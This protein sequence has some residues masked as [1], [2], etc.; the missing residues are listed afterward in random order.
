MSEPGDFPRTLSTAI[1]AIP[2]PV[3]TSAPATATEDEAR[4]RITALEKEARAMGPLPAAALLFHEMGLLWESPLKH[5]R[6]AAV[7]YQSAFKLAP[8]FLAN[9]RAA[10]RLFAEVGN[11]VMVVQLIDA[12]LQATDARRARA[13]LLFEKGQ[14]LEQRLSKETDGAAAVA[15][16]LSLEPEDVTL[17]VQLESYYSEKADYPSLVQVYRLLARH[18]TED[19]ARAVFLTSAGLLLEDRI[20]DLPAAAAAFREAFRFDR[21]D[22]QLLGAIKRVAQREGTV[23]EELAALA[24]EAESQGVSAAPTFLQISKAYERLGRPEDALAALLAARRVSPAD[25]LVLAELARVYEAQLRFTELADVLLSWVQVSTDETEF[26]SINLRL[27]SIYEQLQRDPEASE[28]YQAVLTRAPG[29]VGALSGLGKLHYRTQNWLGLYEAYVAEAAAADDPRLKASRNYKAAETLEERLGQVDQAIAKYNECLMLSPGFLPAQKA[30]TRLYEKHGRWQDLITM[31]E[32][33]LLQTTDRDQQINMLNKIGALYED[34]ISDVDRAIEC[35]KRVLD[36]SPD[37]LPTMH[38]LGRLYERV[39]R[40]SDLLDLNEQETRL[41]SDTKQIVSLAHRN[42]EILEEHVKDRPAAIAAWERVLQLS[43][44]YLPALRALGRL[45]GQ[46]GRWEALIKMYRAEAEIAPSTDQAA[47]LI[48]KIGELY[49]QKVFD[50]DQAIASYREALMLAPTHMPALRSLA[51]IYRSQGAWE[52]LIEILHA[53]AANR[54][55]PTERANA[56]FQ[57]AAIW[58]DHLSRP[59]NAIDGYQEVLRLSPGHTTALQQLE[60]LLTAKDDVKELIVLLDQQTQV[61]TEAARI[62]AW[63]K[64]ARLYLDRLNEPTRAATCC[65][66]ALNIEKTNLTALRLLERIRVND[67]PRRAELRARVAEAIGDPRL[68]AAIKFSSLEGQATQGT[69]VVDQ[70]K[71][72]YAEDPTDEALGLL[73]ERAL[74]RAGDAKG[75]VELYERRRAQATD[76]ADLLQLL[77]RIGDLHETR[78]GDV[79]GAL[80]AYEKALESAPDLFPALMGRTRCALKV[81]NFELART[82]LELVAQT[83]RDATSAMQ[84]LLE[85]ARVAKEKEQ[86]DELAIGLYRKVLDRDPLHAEAGPAL[87]ELLAKR[88]G[89][90]DLVSLHEKRGEAKLA[91]RDVQNAAKEFVDAARKCVDPL[92]DRTRALQFLDRALGAMPGLPDALE[93]KATLALEAQNYVEAAAALAVRVQ[94]GGSDSKQLARLH[95]KLGALY[96]DHLGDPTRAAAHLQS[97]V[98]GDP[99]SVE[100]LERLAAIHTVSRNWTGAAD[101]LRRLLE[102][103]PSTQA[104]AKYTLALARISDEGFNDVGQAITYYRKAM[105][106]VPQDAT[107][108][109]RLVQ[110][111]ERT[112]ALAELVAML[113]QQA[114]QASDVKKAIALK[115]RIAG[116]QSKSLNDPGRS[117]QTWRSILEV[118]PNNLV[119]H[120]ALAELY[121]RDSASIALAIEAH[122]NVLRLDPT[123]AE[124]LHALFRMWESLRQLDKAFCTAALLIFLKSANDTETAFFTEGRNR[125]PSD[126]RGGLGMADL[127]TL[128]HPGARGPVV[129]VLR[130]VGDQFVKLYPPQFELQGIDRKADRQK[131]DSAVYK[132]MQTV[133]TLFGVEDFE[134]YQAKRGLL[135]L[136]TTEPLSACI[137]PDVVRRLNIREQRFLYGRAALGLFDKAAIVRKLAPGEL[138]DVLGNAV[139]I[140]QPNF[141]GLGRRNEEQ[142]RQLRRAFSRKAL[143]A[144]EEPAD[145]VASGAKPGG[146]EGLT[147]SLMF[148]LD[149]AGLVVAADLSAALGL[150]LREEATGAQPRPETAEGVAAGVAARP[151][152]RELMTFALSDDFFRLRQRVGLT[153]G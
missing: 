151:D 85:A 139:R 146:I 16:C 97:A 149:R 77:L 148:S 15:L 26:V 95:L 116:L 117:I 80:I 60:R 14:I 105:E 73:L 84:A 102:L 56:M 27:A 51:R 57:A 71:R 90:A 18:V 129:D 120:A 33:D 3:P 64:L 121:G 130:A 78:T 118:E 41:A 9:I 109:D 17:L 143:K 133:T 141:D 127:V 98:A 125:L 58:E 24:A 104:R 53:E 111:Y 108:L 136:E 94:Q 115:T 49:E 83:S 52:N 144:L 93:L 65:E 67:K 6:N 50:V 62:S 12:E 28:R 48:H 2:I 86:S 81:G 21:R 114:Q 47:T 38:N 44:N 45:Y 150:M 61:G 131:N 91:Q 92:K 36:L 132:A 106:L 140:H 145:A 66:S 107:T 76:S 19:A 134:V 63:I 69:E 112:G 43:P 135:F 68:A 128:H 35:L 31:Y 137:G 147:Q 126:F 103:D 4:A 10:R 30:L 20:K 46:D 138:A 11:W 72:S 99:S 100:A 79:V 13:A 89:A 124:S 25:P 82:T 8:R 75:L 40:W 153:L 54:T 39:G 74:Q 96:H 110:L 37:H 142:T 113:E 7:A 152:I 5:A 88:G 87:E 123:R 32:Q 55:D 1:P 23:D 122:R 29:H 101:C 22:P 42:A 34:R 119:A 70:L 59:K